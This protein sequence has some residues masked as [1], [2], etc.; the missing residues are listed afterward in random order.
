[1]MKQWE[2]QQN[3][4]AMTTSQEVAC[5]TQLISPSLPTRCWMSW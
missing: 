2:V 4:G 1:M 5:L 3:Q